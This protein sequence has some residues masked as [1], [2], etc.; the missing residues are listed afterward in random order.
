MLVVQSGEEDD[1]LGRRASAQS[2]GYYSEEAVCCRETH[3]LEVLGW[4]V[5]C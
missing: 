5:L 2:H 3:T 1:L 4:S